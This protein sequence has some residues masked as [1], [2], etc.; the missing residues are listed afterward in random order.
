MPFTSFNILSGRVHRCTQ[1]TDAT[2]SPHPFCSEAAI[3]GSQSSALRL[4]HFS[5]VSAA[6]G[7]SARPPNLQM[8]VNV[9]GV[10]LGALEL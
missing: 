10:T 7:C 9:N 3:I 5:A 8:F 2:E 4:R 6:Y 1:A